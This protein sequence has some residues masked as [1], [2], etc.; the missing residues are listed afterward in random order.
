MAERVKASRPYP[1]E[2]LVRLPAH[3]AA[4]S[5][6]ARLFAEA[7][8]FREAAP[9]LL[10]A[11]G[12]AIDW[13]A[14]AVWTV[15]FRERV[16]R[17]QSVWHDGGG[18]PEL[19]RASMEL[20]LGWGEGLPG[21]V[22]SNRV[23]QVLPDVLA[24]DRFRRSQAAAR[25]G[26]RGAFGFVV[27]DRGQTLGVIEFFSRAERI[28]DDYTIAMA[29][30]FG[31]QIGQYLSRKRAEDAT[32]ESEG[33]KAGILE[34]ALDAII[35]INH[36]GRI[37]EFN[38]A[39][40]DVFGYTHEQAVGADMA[41]LIIPPSLRDQH[42]RALARAVQSGGG[43]LLGKRLEL[44]GMRSD[45]S[46]FP[47]ELTLARL[48][49]EDPPAF[50]GYVRDISERKRAELRVEL[51]AD[52]GEE[53]TASVD[54]A[55]T[56]AAVE[57]LCVPQLADWCVVDLSGENR[58]IERAV[59]AHSDPDRAELARE[60]EQRPGSDLSSADGLAKAIRSGRSELV[61]EIP[62][63]LLEISADGPEHLALL[64]EVGARSAMTVPLRARGRTLGAISLSNAAG[65]R[66]FEADDLSFAEEI[67]RRAALA[68]DNA[69]MYEERSR[70]ATTLQASLLPP[71]LPRLPGV[72]VASRFRAAGEA[73]QVGGDFFD[74]FATSDR[75]WT[76]VMG[77]V[78]GKGPEAAA[79]TALARYTIR[80]AA[81]HE[82]RPSGVL[83]RL[84]EAILTYQAEGGDR[85]CTA[86]IG[87]LTPTASGG[88][89]A[90]ASGG[91]PLP[92]RLDAAGRV[93]PV[94]APGM[95]I[96]LAPDLELEDVELDLEP[97]DS[98][99]LYTD[100]VTETPTA[101]GLLGE[102]GLAAL[103]ESSR[104]LDAEA[105]LERVD[106]IVVRLQSG[107]PRDDI[108][109]VCLQV[110]DPATDSE[111]EAGGTE[112][113]ASAAISP[114]TPAPSG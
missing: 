76:I 91:H 100:G 60:I 6:I 21:I 44:R 55:S 77:D 17:C 50:A 54:L 24:D 106:R 36:R 7:P 72:A 96:G 27:S 75:H 107:T 1:E 61:S 86:L 70:I 13:E 26:L 49:I 19:E 78:S 114:P 20:E 35:T 94:G 88:R 43:N 51:L 90:L 65:S 11:I 81:A 30:T 22:W 4:Q 33:R 40:E 85:F 84:N 31:N 74:L 102:R 37:V 83:R 57:R 112:K 2:Q 52:A 108:A 32:I 12:R 63:T 73:H 68:I 3:L 16:L 71:R 69:R 98:L 105:L 95:L 67:A 104:G 18:A 62:D 103:I 42:R 29:E 99:L 8:N 34:S 64:R 48:G 97:G 58:R 45:G 23:P 79:V 66:R 14:G 25:D 28:P 80:E 9:R 38:S 92:L 59:V 89:L 46:E 15:D 5:S 109:M 82:E 56:L 87:R 110:R 47:V 41:A 10:E 39:A 111:G 101:G 113:V 53:L 93:G